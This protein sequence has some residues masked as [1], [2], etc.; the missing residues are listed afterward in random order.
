MNEARILE[1]VEEFRNDPCV[2]TRKACEEQIKY[3]ESRKCKS[4]FMQKFADEQTEAL[5]RLLKEL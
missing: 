2:N 1:L 5:K 4:S 3:N